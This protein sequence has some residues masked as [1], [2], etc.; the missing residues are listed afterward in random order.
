MKSQEERCSK[1]KVWGTRVLQIGEMTG[2]WQR[3]PMKSHEE[4]Q[5]G[6]VSWKPNEER[7][8]DQCY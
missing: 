5:A 6:M 8:S 3:R 1:T 2:D 4:S 7:G